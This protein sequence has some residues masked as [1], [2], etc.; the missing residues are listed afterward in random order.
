MWGLDTHLNTV[1]HRTMNVHVPL[2][3]VQMQAISSWPV[4][5]G[6]MITSSK[7]SFSVHIGT[8]LLLIQIL[9]LWTCPRFE[10]LSRFFLSFVTLHWKGENSCVTNVFQKKLLS[11]NLIMLLRPALSLWSW[12]ITINFCFPESENFTLHGT[13]LVT[14]LTDSK[15]RSY[16]AFVKD[17]GGDREEGA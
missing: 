9:K 14:S 10:R 8:W 1:L 15:A 11:P 5:S 13:L 2:T 3:S 7:T 17:G 12:L 6:G 4:W 16:F